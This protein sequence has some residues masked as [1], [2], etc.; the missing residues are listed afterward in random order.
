MLAVMDHASAATQPA[1]SASMSGLLTMLEVNLVVPSSSAP[2][3]EPTQDG[4]PGF[5]IL[6]LERAV[7]DFSTQPPS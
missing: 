6:G 5:D 4:T 3:G 7:E 1:T 2:T